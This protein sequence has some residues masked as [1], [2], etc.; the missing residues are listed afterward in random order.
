[1]AFLEDRYQA[2]VSNYF[3]TGKSPLPC[4]ALATNCFIDAHWNLYPCS[5]WDEKVGNLREAGFDLDTL[6]NSAHA[7]SLRQQVVTE[8]CPHCWTP[9]EA[10]PTILANLRRA[11]LARRVAAS[12]SR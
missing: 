11:V 9:C 3:E 6:W 12:E 10:Y 5:I 1:V 4:T 8:D 7:R 2:L